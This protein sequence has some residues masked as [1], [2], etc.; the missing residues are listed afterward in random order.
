MGMRAM[1]G[2]TEPDE[3]TQYPIKQTTGATIVIS[4]AHSLKVAVSTFERSRIAISMAVVVK[5][6]TGD[7]VLLW[8]SVQYTIKR[9]IE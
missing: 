8:N 2:K 3:K 4:I 9:K 5:R 1:I 6:R 7:D